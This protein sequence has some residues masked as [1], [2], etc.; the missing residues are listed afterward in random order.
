MP[1]AVPRTTA[2]RMAHRDIKMRDGFLLAIF[3]IL[4]IQA[5]GRPANL[6]GY[7]KGSAHR[8]QGKDGRNW[9][10]TPPGR[11]QG[12]APTRYGGGGVPSRG[13]ACP[14]PGAA[15]ETFIFITA[16]RTGPGRPARP[17]RAL[18]GPQWARRA[19]DPVSTC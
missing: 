11:P 9:P 13:W 6:E 10:P 17:G 12:I 7:R 3:I 15:R 5:A 8:R 2:I 4:F 16:R 14:S 18:P 19:D 1:V